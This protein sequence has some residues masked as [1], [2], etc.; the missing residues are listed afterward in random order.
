M[1]RFVSL[2]FVF[3]VLACIARPAPLVGQDTGQTGTIVGRVVD[4]RGG[5]VSGAQVFLTR[6]AIGTQTRAD[7]RYTLTRVPVGPQVLRVRMLGF[8]PDSASVTVSAGQEA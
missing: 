8:R 5:T 1:N 6:P 2:A 4:E 7:G 3:L